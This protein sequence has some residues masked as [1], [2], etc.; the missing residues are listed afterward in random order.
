MLAACGTYQWWQISNQIS[1][2]TYNVLN[3]TLNFTIPY[4]TF[5]STTL[6]LSLMSESL[7]RLSFLLWVLE[8]SRVLLPLFSII[9]IFH[10]VWFPKYFLKMNQLNW[11]LTLWSQIQLIPARRRN[12][13]C[14][15]DATVLIA[16]M[17]VVTILAVWWGTSYLLCHS[18][19]H[20]MTYAITPTSCSKDYKVS[21]SCIV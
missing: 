19:A 5:G 3:A 12:S 21:F 16:S 17:L 14:K 20:Q 1:E 4:H 10:F 15:Q 13:S 8:E 6:K 11:S 2:M 7:D 18:S 9:N